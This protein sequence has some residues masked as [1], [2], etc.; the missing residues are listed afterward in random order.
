MTPENFALEHELVL[1]EAMKLYEKASHVRGQMWLEFPP[2]D[3]IRELRERVTR[4]KHA[5]ERML[6][7]GGADEN[8]DM[9]EALR[10]A[11]VDDAID[12][13]NYAAFLV[14]QIRRGESG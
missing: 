11:I 9:E 2:S 14:K 12:I 4:I 3:K 1:K 13:I 8:D 5:H 10:K 6:G 7:L